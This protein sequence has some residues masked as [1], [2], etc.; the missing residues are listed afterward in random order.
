MM[1]TFN[2]ISSASF[3]KN[4]QPSWRRVAAFVL[5][6]FWNIVLLV[7]M[8][9]RGIEI[10]HLGALLPVYYYTDFF[11]DLRELLRS[12]FAQMKIP[13]AQINRLRFLS[14]NLLAHFNYDSFQRY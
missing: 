10:E 8:I 11:K 14:I 4:V 1:K 3:I 12:C 2:Y 7:G 5:K 9:S 13:L 6:H